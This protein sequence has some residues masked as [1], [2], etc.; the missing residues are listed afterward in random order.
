TEKPATMK[1]Q[2]VIEKPATVEN[3]KAMENKKQV[4]GLTRAHL[5]ELIIAHQML[6]KARNKKNNKSN[7]TM[8]GS[9]NRNNR[10]REL[11]NMLLRE[12]G[13]NA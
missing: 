11:L 9:A 10:N 7:G 8:N 5:D 13:K 4:A 1:N 3:Q 12:L 2:K 6:M